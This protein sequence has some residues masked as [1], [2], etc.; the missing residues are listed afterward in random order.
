MKGFGSP[1]GAGGVG[2]WGKNGL[3]PGPV[4]SLRICP[5]PCSALYPAP[6]PVP[7]S[8]LYSCS[9]SC[10]NPCPSPFPAAH[11]ALCLALCFAPYPIWCPAPRFPHLPPR[12]PAR[13]LPS[14]LAHARPAPHLK[15]QRVPLPPG[16]RSLGTAPTSPAVHLRLRSPGRAPGPGGCR[17]CPPAPSPAA[18]PERAGC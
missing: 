9:I 14:V 13:A 4:G 16:F 12:L 1:R 3:R 8:P 11:P 5:V 17:R 10:P 2:G 18:R 7:P 15:P 6:H